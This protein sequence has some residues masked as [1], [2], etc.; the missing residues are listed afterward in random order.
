MSSLR[1]RFEDPAI[2]MTGHDAEGRW[3]NRGDWIRA[4]SNGTLET[5]STRREITTKCI[6]EADCELI[7][8]W[9]E[10]VL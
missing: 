6:V 8:C 3:V 5:I 10:S 9:I 4:D 7:S 1:L 2:C